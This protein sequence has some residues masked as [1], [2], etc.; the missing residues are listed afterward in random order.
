MLEQAEADLQANQ[1]Y[2]CNQELLGHV[3]DNFLML[4]GFYT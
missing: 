2:V 4:C 1:V 3:Y